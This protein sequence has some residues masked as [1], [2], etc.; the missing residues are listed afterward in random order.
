ML[1]AWSSLLCQSTEYAN[2][3]LTPEF[4]RAVA[5]VRGDVEV[6][7]IEDGQNLLGVFPFQRSRPKSGYPVGGRLSNCHA[8]L[9]K[10]DVQ[11]SLPKLL[12]T[13]GLGSWTF[14]QLVD[15]SGSVQPMAWQKADCQ[16]I[17]LAGGFGAYLQRQEQRTNKFQKI[18]NRMRKL[19]REVGPLEFVLHTTKEEVLAKLMEWKAAQFRRSLIVDIFRFDW[20]KQLL[21]K[22]V[23]T[24]SEAFQPQVS[25][26]CAGGHL[27][28]AAFDLQFGSTIDA[29]LTAFDRRFSVYSPGS[30]LLQEKL[31]A[32][33]DLGI[34]RYIMGTGQEDYKKSF[35]TDALPMWKGTITQG[36]LCGTIQ[37]HS[38]QTKQ[39]LRTLPGTRWIRWP[40]R[41]FKALTD[42][43]GL[44]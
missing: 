39:W 8:L 26:L 31:K 43:Q 42:Y 34:S 30:I 18:A 22:L 41:L 40:A 37:K 7:L 28:A 16:Y 15:P 10:P 1:A 27:V 9:I 35:I 44:R 38:H 19:E 2:P 12:E 5:D 21:A 32:Y 25:A 17:N 3:F 6:A 33:A 4:S 20:V 14:H 11:I 13:C 36:S 29:W 24:P 23:Q